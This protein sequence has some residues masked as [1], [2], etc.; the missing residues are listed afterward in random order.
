MSKE[1]NV[2][3][4]SELRKIQKEEDKEEE[5]TELDDK[6]LLRVSNY[7]DKKKETEGENSREYKNARRVLDKIISLR[8]EKV[9]KEA[10]LSVKTEGRGNEVSLLPEEQ[11]LFRKIKS[12]FERHR[13]RVDEKV[14]E[15][16]LNMSTEPSED[17]K[18]EVNTEKNTEIEENTSGKAVN[19]QVEESKDSTGSENVEDEADSESLEENTEDLEETEEGY[20]LVKTTSDV[21]EFMGTDLEAYGPFDEG[22]KVEIPDDNAEILVN[23]GN[24]ERIES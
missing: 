15:D 1:G 17:V 4:F 11:E 22:E 12:D 21:P 19:A 24:A 8:E 20:T 16:S 2:L 9:I 14:E 3:T 6:F 7:F 23:R 13:S 18:K 5:L 10:R